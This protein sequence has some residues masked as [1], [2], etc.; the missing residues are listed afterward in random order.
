MDFQQDVISPFELEDILGRL[1]PTPL[2]KIGGPEWSEQVKT[3][4]M[5]LVQMCKRAENCVLFH[6][7]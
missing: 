6:F 7:Y 5:Y 1:K 4:T 3:I 2:E